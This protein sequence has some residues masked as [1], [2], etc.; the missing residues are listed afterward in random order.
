MSRIR[1]VIAD[2][3]RRV[4]ALEDGIG[5][6]HAA[7]EAVKLGAGQS[8]QPTQVINVP[9]WNN[10]EDYKAL[11]KGLAL[12]GAETTTRDVFWGLAKGWPG[13]P[14]SCT[15]TKAAI[16]EAILEAD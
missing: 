6:V 12:Y 14:L 4:T 8:S 11:A 13:G 10:P 2:L 5:L 7:M 1:K 9:N 16:C 15:K 3:V